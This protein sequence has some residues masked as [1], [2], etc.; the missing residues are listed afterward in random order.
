[1]MFA[2]LSKLS[3]LHVKVVTTFEKIDHLRSQIDGL[4]DGLFRA[5]E[6]IARVEGAIANSA[7]AEILRSS[8][9]ESRGNSAPP[10]LRMEHNISGGSARLPSNK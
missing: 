5:F 2:W 8:N 3:D 10:P 4:G 9:V 1:M 7:T 6:K